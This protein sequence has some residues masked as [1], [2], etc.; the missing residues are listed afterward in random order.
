MA[1]QMVEAGVPLIQIGKVLRHQNLQSIGIY[2]RV[3]VERLR[4]LAL[5]WPGSVPR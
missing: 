3:D 4:D 1:C 5:P 2:A